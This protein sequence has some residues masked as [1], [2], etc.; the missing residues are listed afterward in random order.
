MAESRSS[1]T[2]RAQRLARILRA[3]REAAGV[4]QGAAASHIKR[5]QAVLS[6]V[7]GAK[8]LC[9]Y[10]DVREL[11]NLYGV[12]D[13]TKRDRILKLAKD[14]HKHG[15]FDS[16][17]EYIVEPLVDNAYYE[18]IAKSIFVFEPTNIPGL[19][20]TPAHAR[21]VI[22][23]ADFL[24][25]APREEEIDFRLERQGVLT[26][27][28]KALS[29]RVVIGEAALHR[30]VGGPEVHRE[31][32]H[33]LL[34]MMKLPNIHIQILP[35]AV[36]AHV[37]PDGQFTVALADPVDP[38]AYCDSSAGTVYVEGEDVDRYR[39]AWEHLSRTALNGRES[40]RLI[41]R[42]LKEV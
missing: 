36:G 39:T 7:E 14:V 41:E 22:E 31:Q 6:R 40:E 18:G 11:L 35:F 37:S 21:E 34:A 8:Q 4:S 13:A 17:D 24:Q 26:R 38:I 15:W 28:H 1:V 9:P 2:M 19:L 29:Y 42:I 20:Q 12:H 3:L 27:P 32:L 30:M 5:D 10:D 25:K 33:H 16:Y 23:K